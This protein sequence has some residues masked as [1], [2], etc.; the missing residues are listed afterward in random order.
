[1]AINQQ[2][3]AKAVATGRRWIPDSGV[4]RKVLGYARHLGLTV[5]SHAEDNGLAGRAS[6][7]AGAAATRLGRGSAP[8]LAGPLASARALVL[9]EQTGWRQHVR[10]GTN[11]NG[12]QPR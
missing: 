12:M 7:T 3:G 2:A 1:M 6:G 11:T 10:Q 9:Y 4:M 5:V 8:A